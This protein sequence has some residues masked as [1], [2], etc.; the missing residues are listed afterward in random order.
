M[1][2][3][4]LLAYPNAGSAVATLRSME[5]L[6]LPS[7]NKSRMFCAVRNSN[8][9]FTMPSKRVGLVLISS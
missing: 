2:C 4:V 1:Q 5:I 6:F 7:L 8:W 9:A 3:E